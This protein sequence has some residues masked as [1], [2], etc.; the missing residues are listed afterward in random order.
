MIGPFRRLADQLTL[1][2]LILAVPLWVFALLGQRL[3]LGI[4]LAIAGLTDVLDG[5]IA[6]RQGR[7]TKFG[8]QMDSIADH[9]LFASTLVWLVMFRPDFFRGY[10]V[11]LIAWAALATATLIVGLVRY[12]RFAN[13]HLYSAKTAGVVGYL[14]ALYMVMFDGPATPYFWITFALAAAAT[15]ETLLIFLTRGRADEHTGTIFRRPP[16]TMA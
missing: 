2:R 8:S 14:F 7:P 5:P 4:G 16:R 11:W 13:L 9:T 1:L 12:R 10:G 15:T 6:R 3:L